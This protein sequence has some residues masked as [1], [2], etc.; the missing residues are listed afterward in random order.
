MV[1][2]SFCTFHL[3]LWDVQ[4]FIVSCVIIGNFIPLIIL[5]PEALKALLIYYFVDHDRSMK[6]DDLISFNTLSRNPFG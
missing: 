4:I 1:E 5:I 3:T 6:R 2:A